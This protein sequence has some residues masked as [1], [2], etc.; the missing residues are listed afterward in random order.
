MWNAREIRFKTLVNDQL[1]RV[2]LKPLAQQNSFII[3]WDLLSDRIDKGDE[4]VLYQLRGASSRGLI[5]MIVYEGQDKEILLKNLA[6]FKNYT[7][8]IMALYRDDKTNT[9]IDRKLVSFQTPSDG[10]SNTKMGLL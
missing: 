5:D 2:K 4:R 3:N 7:F 1:I 6:P 10:K 8:E 9:I